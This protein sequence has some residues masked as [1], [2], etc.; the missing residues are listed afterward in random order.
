MS[1]EEF[2][3][4]IPERGNQLCAVLCVPT[5]AMRDLGAVLLTGGNYTRSH[6]NRM[7]V[8]T[9]RALAAHGV[10][11]IRFDYHGVGDSTGSGAMKMDEPFKEDVVAAID[12]LMRAT[13]VDRVALGATCFGG[14]NALA[15]AA[16]H[17]GVSSVTMFPVQLAAQANVTS[18]PLRSKGRLWLRKSE[19]GSRL[20]RTGPMRKWRKR[21]AVG[22]PARV[23]VASPDV[24]KQ[25]VAIVR[26]ARIKFIYGELT[27]SLPE[28]RR[29][30]E[31][32][33]QSLSDEEANRISVDIVPGTVLHRFQTLRDQDHVVEGVVSSVLDAAAA[34]PGSASEP[35]PVR[36]S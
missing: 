17:A 10:A 3:L 13:H 15:A 33:S 25:I 20:L 18:V 16:E 32:V 31:E 9:A 34:S 23:D 30:L 8:R 6:R 2:G 14:R 29:L 4:F 35:L 36:V 19:W 1:F 21:L 5:G 12:F 7:W 26:R 27:E 24:K 22:R 28:L 11:S